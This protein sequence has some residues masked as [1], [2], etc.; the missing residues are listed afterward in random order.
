MVSF[1]FLCVNVQFLKL[2]HTF[3]KFKSKA[4]WE[5]FVY[6]YCFPNSCSCCSAASQSVQCFS[7]KLLCRSRGFGSSCR[8]EM[9]LFNFFFFFLQFLFPATRNYF[10]FQLCFCTMEESSLCGGDGFAFFCFFSYVCLFNAA[11]IIT[12]WQH[13]QSCSRQE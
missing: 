5:F 2:T 9:F 1:R 4:S 10:I 12:L 11:V 8:E 7:L 13:K 6:H 3:L